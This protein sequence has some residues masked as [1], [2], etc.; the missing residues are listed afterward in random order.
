MKMSEKL[1]FFQVAYFHYRFN[2]YLLISSL[3][4]ASQ[5]ETNLNILILGSMLIPVQFLSQTLASINL[6]HKL[7]VKS[8]RLLFFETTKIPLGLG[9]VYFL[10]LG[11]SGA[12][13]TLIIAYIVRLSVQGYFGRNKIRSSM[14]FSIFKKMDKFFWISL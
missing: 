14:H 6:G 2:S 3:L 8:Y 4:V 5:I 9:F 11:T 1:Q 13:Y 7:H 12:I 10:D